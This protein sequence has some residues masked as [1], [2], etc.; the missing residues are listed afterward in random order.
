MVGATTEVVVNEIIRRSSSKVFG[1]FIDPAEH[2]G[3]SKT[4]CH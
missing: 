1:R 3:Q 2:M 4:S